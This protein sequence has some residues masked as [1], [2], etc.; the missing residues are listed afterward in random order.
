MVNATTQTS[1]TSTNQVEEQ[2]PRGYKQTEVGVI[3]E[4]WKILPLLSVVQIV[5]GQVD[6]KTKPYRT[7]VLVAPDHIESGTGRLLK[8]LT[9]EEQGAISGKHLFAPGDIVY[10][11]IRPYLMKATLADFNGLC[12]ADM[13]PMKPLPGI[14]G[15]LVLAVILGRRFTSYAESVSVRSGIPKINRVE[16]AEYNIALP[17]TLTEQQAIAEALGDA[18]AYIESLEQL[19]TK[20]RQVKQGAMQELLTGKRRL[21]GFSG[22]WEEKTLGEL[23]DFIKGAGVTR[24]QA[25]SGT[26]A[27]V[28]YGEIYTH[29][30]N[31][32]REFYSWISSQIATTAIRLRK[33]DILF[34]G[35]GET[36]EEIGK[37]A[38]F[39]S[40]IEAYA[41]GDII[42]L[43]PYDAESSFLGYYLNSEIISQQKASRGQG[44]AVVHISSRA[45][46][47][48]RCT[49][50]SL[51]EQLAIANILLD[52]DIEITKLETKLEKARRIKQGM[53]QE[54][55]TGKVR[56]I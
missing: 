13:Y 10:S 37:C 40:E 49:I 47:D 34:A 5:S 18:D 28:R 16:L 29:H 56:L 26:I 21:P 39:L 41:G 48:I 3:P 45:L 42:I 4:D 30:K 14:S 38:A 11:K 46:S 50:P 54:L 44:D 36:K 43:R 8:K 23:G 31:I 1:T 15:G 9:A 25:Q 6:P 51:S 53:M 22:E 27:C 32:I 12:S 17:P 2:V 20:K 19:I 24:D 35:S 7:M 52:M 33:G 55:L